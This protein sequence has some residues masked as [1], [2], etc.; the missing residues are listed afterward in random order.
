MKKFICVLTVL[1]LI[2]SLTACG[3]NNTENGSTEGGAGTE[4]DTTSQGD[5]NTEADNSS[6]PEK[7]YD[8]YVN[9]VGYDKGVTLAFEVTLTAPDTEFASCCP[10]FNI[11][12]EGVTDAEQIRASFSYGEEYINP[13]LICNTSSP[14][15]NEDHYSDWGYYDVYARFIDPNGELLDCTNGLHIYTQELTFKE[16][17]NYTIT[18]TSG[19]GEPDMTEWF[20]K[21]D[22]CFSI[23]ITEVK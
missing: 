15:H 22:D 6:E 14:Q 11:Y 17:G 5:T 7:V 13:L 8:V 16:A 20:A 19:N 10:S 23:K 9:G 12:K 18:V 21:Y 2:F 3:G 4:K 1:C